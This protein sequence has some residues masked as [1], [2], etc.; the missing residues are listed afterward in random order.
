MNAKRPKRLA[1]VSD[2]GRAKDYSGCGSGKTGLAKTRRRQSEYREPGGATYAVRPEESVVGL[3]S[4]YLYTVVEG[5]YCKIGISVNP[6]ARAKW[7]QCPS[8]FKLPYAQR[9]RTEIAEWR[10]LP[11]MADKIERAIIKQFKAFR[12]GHGDEWFEVPHSIL[13]NSVETMI[14]SIG[15][16]PQTARRHFGKSERPR[17][18]RAFKLKKD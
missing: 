12:C 13:V 2:P 1:V 10:Y 18:N 4:C 17:G 14:T 15:W 3:G 5:R 11:G 16:T 7:I 9:P 8:H 6:L